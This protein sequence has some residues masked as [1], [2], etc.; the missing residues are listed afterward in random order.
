MSTFK[1]K[2]FKDF[3]ILETMIDS[4]NLEELQNNIA[5]AVNE[6]RAFIILIAGTVI[7][8]DYSITIP[9]KYIV[10]DNSLEVFWNGT[11]LIKATSVEDGHYK[12]FGEEGALS[13]TIKM[14]R[15]VTD[16][17]YTLTQD[18]VLEFVVRGVDQN[19]DF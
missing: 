15:T 10:G 19:E 18:V 6:D 16:G 14:Y 11:K 13:N 8:N 9:L 17:N 2:I 5:T 1:K 7:T 3:P 4:E 12:E